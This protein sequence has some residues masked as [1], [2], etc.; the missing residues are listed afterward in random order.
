LRGDSN[1]ALEL[2]KEDLCSEKVIPGDYIN[3]ARSFRKRDEM[4]QDNIG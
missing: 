3:K 4:E 1:W 2:F